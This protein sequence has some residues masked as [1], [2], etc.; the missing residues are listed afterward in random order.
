MAKDEQVKNQPDPK[1]DPKEE[2]PQEGQTEQGEPDLVDRVAELHGVSKKV[3]RQLITKAH[4]DLIF[5]R[6]KRGR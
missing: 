4:E 6:I 3:A 1:E 5:D 2:T